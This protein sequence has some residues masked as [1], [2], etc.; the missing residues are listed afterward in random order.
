MLAGWDAAATSWALHIVSFD[1]FIKS[2]TPSLSKLK[3]TPIFYFA[4]RIPDD[5]TATS[6]QQRGLGPGGLG[7]P[8]SPRFLKSNKKGIKNTTVENN[9]SK[10]CPLFRSRSQSN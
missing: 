2:M 4:F 3:V 8:G 10:K 5:V 6:A 7:G 1:N 9:I